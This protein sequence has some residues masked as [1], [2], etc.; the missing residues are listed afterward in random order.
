METQVYELNNIRLNCSQ[1]IL[2][3]EIESDKK[4]TMRAVGV[5]LVWLRSKCF[6]LSSSVL[7]QTR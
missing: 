4:F 7:V 2:Q 3:M 6:Y 1:K 5:V